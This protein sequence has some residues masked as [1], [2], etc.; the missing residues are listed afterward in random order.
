MKNSTSA[1]KILALLV[2]LFSGS[3]P[4][5]LKTA[6]IFLSQERKNISWRSFPKGRLMN[7]GRP[8]KLE[9]KKQAKNLEPR[10]SGKVPRRRM[11]GLNR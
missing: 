6:V 1:P 9:Q 8:F 7:T 10:F 4:V 5:R 11:T 3:F 2:F